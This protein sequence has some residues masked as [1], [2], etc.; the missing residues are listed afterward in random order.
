M[1]REFHFGGTQLSGELS[2]LEIMRITHIG[3]RLKRMVHWQQN[4]I[5]IDP[6]ELW[7]LGY[8]VKNSM[9]RAR[10]IYIQ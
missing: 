7:G 2:K 5:I 10:F 3:R 9:A 8:K 4:L 6:W 1:L